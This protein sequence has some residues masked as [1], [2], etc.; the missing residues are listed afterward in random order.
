MANEALPVPVLDHPRWRVVIR[1]AEFVRDRIPSLK[2]CGEI[3]ERSTVRLRGWPFP[4]IGRDSSRSLRGSDWIGHCVEFGGHIEY[5]R[6]YQS[7]QFLF[8]G[9]V[10]ERAAEDWDAKLRRDSKQHPGRFSPEE[11]DRIPG[12]LSLVNVIY[13]ITEYLEFAARLCESGAYA[14]PLGITIGLHGID[15]YV[16]TT[17]PM[18][19][20]WLDHQ[21]SSPDLSHTW[22]T[23]SSDL[24]ETRSS[25]ALDIMVWFFERFGWTE[26]SAKVLQDEQQRFLAGKV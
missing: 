16:L 6:L 10:R 5:W 25:F 20:W 1:P 26:A 12:F 17:E 23:T 19:A 14:G 3:V 13:T 24:I 8:L 15:G 21:C 9:A 2:Q 4:F 18:R 22:N 11:V 7:G